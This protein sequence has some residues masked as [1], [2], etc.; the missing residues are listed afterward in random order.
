MPGGPNVRVETHA[1]QGYKVPPNYDS[2]IGK[3]LTHGATRDDAIA[4]MRRALDEFKVGPIKTT[5]P[6]HRQIMANQEFRN[7]AVDTGWIERTYKPKS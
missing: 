3:L 1:H 4:T 7:S 5:I 6:L 2:M